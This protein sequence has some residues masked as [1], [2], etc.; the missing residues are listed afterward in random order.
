MN[1][2]GQPGLPREHRRVL[3][4]AGAAPPPS[5]SSDPAAPPPRDARVVDRRQRQVGARS[6][7]RRQRPLRQ[8]KVGGAGSSSP[9]RHVAEARQQRRDRPGRLAPAR[10]E[11]AVV[12]LVSFVVVLV[13]LGLRVPI[14]IGRRRRAGSRRRV[15]RVGTDGLGLR[16]NAAAA[17]TATALFVIAGRRCGWRRRGRR[18]RDFG[19]CRHCC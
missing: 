10:E 19:P 1:V 11:E 13:T 5:A 14:D 2:E 6:P 15:R 9:R 16:G 4:P 12:V 3:G 17:D 7:S 8:G 18:R